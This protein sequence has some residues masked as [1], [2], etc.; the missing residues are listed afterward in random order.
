MSSRRT[1]FP[2]FRVNLLQI[3]LADARLKPFFEF[4]LKPRPVL[5]VIGK[6]RMTVNHWYKLSM[7]CTIVK[8]SN[9]P[10]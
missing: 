6:L 7:L 5:S 4:G 2:L 1:P 9:D 10:S 8:I 3:V